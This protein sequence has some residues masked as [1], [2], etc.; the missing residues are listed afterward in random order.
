MQ[1]VLDPPAGSSG[2]FPGPGHG[3]VFPFRPTCHG[4]A[5]VFKAMEGWRDTLIFPQPVWVMG[6]LFMHPWVLVFASVVTVLTMYYTCLY[7]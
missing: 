2:N 7:M 4:S 1:T 3:S 5:L 6:G